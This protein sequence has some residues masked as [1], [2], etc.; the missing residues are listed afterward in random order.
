MQEHRFTS[1]IDP[2][3][4]SRDLARLAKDRNDIVFVRLSGVIMLAHPGETG[5]I[6]YGRWLEDCRVISLRRSC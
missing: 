3:R 2:E 4:A 6:V 5:T 1:A